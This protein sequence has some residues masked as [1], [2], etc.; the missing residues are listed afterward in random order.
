MNFYIIKSR[1][2]FVLKDAYRDSCLKIYFDNKQIKWCNRMYIF[3]ASTR[4]VQTNA[5]NVVKNRYKIPNLKSIAFMN[6]NL[7]K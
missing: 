6:R 7:V 5:V 1:L 4:L 3:F 2:F